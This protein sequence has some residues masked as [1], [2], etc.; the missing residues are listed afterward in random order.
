M[1]SETLFQKAFILRKP[2]AAIFADT[3]KIVIMSV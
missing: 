3:I 1:T 2:K